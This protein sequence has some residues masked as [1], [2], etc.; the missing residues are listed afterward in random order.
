MKPIGGAT[1]KDKEQ[2]DIAYR[3]LKDTQQADVNNLEIF[4]LVGGKYK[5]IAVINDYEP[6]G[7][8][9]IHLKNEVQIAVCTLGESNPFLEGGTRNTARPPLSARELFARQ[10]KACLDMAARLGDQLSFTLTGSNNSQFALVNGDDTLSFA[11]GPIILDLQAGQ[12]EIAFALL[13]TGDVDTDATLTLTATYLPAEG[14]AQATYDLTLHFDA[15]EEPDPPTPI[16]TVN[17]D[18]VPTDVQPEVPGIQAL[19]DAQGNPIGEAGAY[20]D[21]LSGSAGNDHLLAGELNDDVGS[22]D[23]DGDG[24]G[25]GDDWIEGGNGQDYL[26]GENG[27]DLIEGGNGSDIVFGEAGNDRLYGHSQITLEA[28]IAAGNTGTASGLKGDWLSGNAGDDLLISGADHDVLAGGAGADV[29]IAGAGDDNLL[30]DADYVP[31]FIPEATRRYSIGSISWYHGSTTTFDWGYTDTADVRLF[32]PVRGETNPVGGAGDALHAGA[33]DDRAWAGEGDDN[34]W[35]EDGNDTL[36]GD[37]GNDVMLGGAG[38][39]RIFGDASYID[40]SL[41]GNDFLDGGDGDDALYGDSGNTP[42]TAMGDDFLDGGDNGIG[43][44]KIKKCDNYLDKHR[45]QRTKMRDVEKEKLKMKLY[46]LV[47]LLASIC[48]GWVSGAIAEPLP[49][50]ATDV[51]PMISLEKR[52]VRS[53]TNLEQQYRIDLYRDLTV[54]FHGFANT[55]IKGEARGTIS[56]DRLIKI[57]SGF[58]DIRFLDLDPIYGWERRK[59]DQPVVE[60]ED[61]FTLTLRYREANHTVQ[62]SS[63]VPAGTPPGVH[64]LIDRIKQASGGRQW[65]CPAL[66]TQSPRVSMDVCEFP[67]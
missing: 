20:E 11:D 19:G 13:N 43:I 21:M 67:E 29:L 49:K 54:V 50:D 3:L 41:H 42:E 51:L 53:M 62:V 28:A 48:I 9:G 66:G 47:A 17:G 56:Q 61:L 24:S 12:T 45:M 6:G 37:A 58:S 40:G 18:I 4:Q 59:P 34:V 30:G 22:G 23:G 8:L 2:G 32:S 55:R 60:G 33:G 27:N 46:S 14:G 65:A 52:T 31:Q 16:L 39:D 7:D 10:L 5:Q 63:V 64:L 25:D 15:T 44:L 26:H 38:N 35:G 1:W 57:I 36:S